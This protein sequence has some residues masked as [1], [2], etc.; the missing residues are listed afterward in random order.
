VNQLVQLTGV[1]DA[2][3]DAVRQTRRAAV[4]PSGGGRRPE[5]TR[6]RG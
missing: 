1:T 2:V 4:W 6:T 3:A 5:R